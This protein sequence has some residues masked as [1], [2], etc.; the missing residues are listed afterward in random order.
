[1][2]SFKPI[3]VGT[4]AAACLFVHDV[5]AAGAQP[6]PSV[7]VTT[8]AASPDPSV[9]VASSRSAVGAEEPAAPSVRWTP[10][11]RGA[12]NAALQ[13]PDALRRFVQRT[14]TIY[15]LQYSDFAPFVR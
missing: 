7:I 6:D 8:P 1:M 3:I 11:M 13:G 5:S 2:K 15:A 10:G 14:R 12:R 9:L 4:A